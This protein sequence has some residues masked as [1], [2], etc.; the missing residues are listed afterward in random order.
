MFD[1]VSDCVGID[2]SPI[3][4]SVQSSA[5]PEVDLDDAMRIGNSEGT[6]APTPTLSPLLPAEIDAQS[7]SNISATLETKPEPAGAAKGA[8]PPQ[9][10]RVE[11]EHVD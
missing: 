11:F 6:R 10:I 8:A 1:F 2:V 3:G 9:T 7:Q 4:L 5:I